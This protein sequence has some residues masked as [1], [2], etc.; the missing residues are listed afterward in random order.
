MARF[1]C[2]KCD[3]SKEVPDDYLGR[4]ARCPQ[5][6][7][8][9]QVVSAHPLGRPDEGDLNLDDLAA[10]FSEDQARESGVGGTGIPSAQTHLGG[11][12]NLDALE[13][14]DSLTD[15]PGQV[16]PPVSPGTVRRLL[17]GLGL[18]CAVVFFCLGLAL[19]PSV[20]AGDLALYPLLLQ[21]A[22][23]AALFGGLIYT[24]RSRVSFATAGPES[25]SCAGLFLLAQA[26]AANMPGSGGS[27]VATLV[28][29]MLAT[30]LLSGLF[31]LL[32]SR[33]RGGDW[34][35]FVPFP[36]LG[37]VL[38]GLGLLLLQI[39]FQ[40]RTGVRL[41]LE[42]LLRALHGTDEVLYAGG[43]YRRWLPS[44]LF[45]VLL[46]L[47]YRRIRA[48]WW[49][50]LP[51]L[52]GLGWSAAAPLL[53]RT[54]P[55]A[56]AVEW[57]GGTTPPMT[58]GGLLQLHSP[59]LLTGTDWSVLWGLPGL[60]FSV[61]LLL[62]LNA[63][64]KALVL[65]ENLGREV[66][67]GPELR[68]LGVAN[69]VSG[70]ASG[71]PVSLSL[72]RSLGSLRAGGLGLTG[73]LAA[74]AVCGAALFLGGPLLATVP[75]FIPVG[76]L[77]FMG[78]NLLKRW[79]VDVVAEDL[80]AEEYACLLLAFA[81]TVGIGFVPG[82]V[83]GSFLALM[84]GLSR[85]STTAAIK[86]IMSGGAHH[87]NV[88]R[89]P[90]Q[91]DALQYL[92][93]S[94]FILR[95]QGFLSSGSL[96]AA[97]RVVW[98]RLEEP[99]HRPLRFV[100]LDFTLIKGFGSGLTRVFGG[101]A[102]LGRDLGVRMVLT[103]V[104]FVL[105]DRLEKAGLAGEEQ[106]AFLLFRNLDYALEWCEDRLLEAEG[107]QQAEEPPLADLLAP[108]FP[109]KDALPL[110]MRI[111]QRVDVRDGAYVF[112]QGDASDSMYFVESGMLTV[113]LEIPD[114]KTVRL[115]KLGPGSV[116]GEMG[117]YT[118]AERSASVRANEPS[119]VRR[120]SKK[121]LAV[122]KEKQPHLA[123][124]LD[125]FLVTLLARRVADAN[126]MVRDLMR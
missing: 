60:I 120:L 3:I 50:G 94:I 83:V 40:A 104:S 123:T 70:L 113:E 82:V 102:R 100:V 32:F 8:V 7:A 59:F 122:L 41:D 109:D 23:T 45:G 74:S 95:M 64:S 4:K 108:V 126:V 96:S 55:G 79:L 78:L 30:A 124:S 66:S 10:D 110:L 44:L 46:F 18:G 76:L 65:E 34:M 85:H 92:G 125:R 26:V 112:R 31:C 119:V 57:L 53:A 93:E 87:S 17:N 77:C 56:L 43:A 1:H 15:L 80:R 107:L 63:S 19:A 42:L 116:F 73:A 106:G 5:C 36:V 14:S 72:G 28:C 114:G 6:G 20:G 38:A 52:L 118:H 91:A 98:E 22:L 51:L 35:R 97:L 49:L 67:P 9:L 90:A 25:V 33:V 21:M 71:F 84:L 12:Q 121:R 54:G 75:P 111:L 29:A 115:K 117:L 39:A 2:A 88:D 89:A 69:L 37:G 48:I 24:L 81:V 105:E 47:A 58:F 13:A 86:S 27:A 103:N 16:S 61:A 62:A 99:G 68:A 11:E 101:L